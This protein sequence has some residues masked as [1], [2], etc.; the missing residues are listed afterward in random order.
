[1]KTVVYGKELNDE[2]LFKLRE[3][4]TITFKQIPFKNYCF[5]LKDDYENFNDPFIKKMETELIKSADGKEYIKLYYDGNFARKDTIEKLKEYGI[6][7]FEG[8]VD[9]IK[10][11]LIINQEVELH[12][13]G[14]KNVFIDIETVDTKPLTYDEKD[15][16]IANTPITAIA[17]KDL[18]G[19]INYLA[20][21]GYKKLNRNSSKIEV[22]QI[23]FEHEEALL[24]AYIDIIKEYD[25][26]YAWNGYRFD[27]PWLRQR[28]EIHKLSYP[29]I[30]EIDYLEMYKKD[31]YLNLQSFNLNNV[32]VH[33][34][35]GMIK[36]AITD[37]SFKFKDLKEVT[38]LDWKDITKLKKYYELAICEP[39]IMKEYNVQDVNLMLMIEEKNMFIKIHEMQAKIAHCLIKETMHNSNVSDYVIFKECI[40]RNIIRKS[41]PTKEEIEKIKELPGGA[42]TFCYK[43]GFY[44]NIANFDFKSHYPTSM[45]NFN[46]SIETYAGKIEPELE[47][48]FNKD[49]ISLINYACKLRIG[50]MTKGFVEALIKKKQI[51]LNVQSMEDLMF[52]F[53]KDY[54]IPEKLK[55]TDCIITPADI[56]YD[57]IGWN[58]HP[59]RYFK[60]I[61]AIIPKIC[62]EWLDKRDELKDK[63]K[64][65]MK[66]KK[67]ELKTVKPEKEI[68]ALVNEMPEYINLKLS[69]N[70]IKINL[71]SFYGYFG[72][73]GSRDYFYELPDTITTIGRYILKTMIHLSSINKYNIVAG[74]TDSVYIADVPQDKIVD[75][76]IIYYDF[77]KTFFK[78]FNVELVKVQKNPKTKELEN[79]THWTVFQLD[80]IVKAAIFIK[81]KR[82]YYLDEDE[83]K[84]Q[85]G[86]FKKTNTI[87]VAAKV[88]K[89]IVKKIL[90]DEFNLDF[91]NKYLNQ[92]SEDTFNNKLLI[93]D[94]TKYANVT[95]KIE[96][97]GK[98]VVDKKTG[99][100][101]I[102]KNGKI[103]YAPIPVH[104]EVAK[105]MIT[106]G[107]NVDV[108]EKIPYI[109]INNKPKLSGVHKEEFE[110]KNLTYCAA[111]YWT[112]IVS[113]VLEILLVT[114]KDLAMNEL[115]KYWN[116]TDK[117]VM[118]RAKQ[119]KTL[120]SL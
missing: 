114:H 90:F 97:Y 86:A 7:V 113:V 108:G 55:K 14:L 21:Q 102:K 50:S 4:D 43:P 58:V 71:N 40:K 85:G 73:R 56:N 51:E 111:Y 92:L 78:Q 80:K 57:V 15:K 28:C 65:I 13:E 112:N 62:A 67:T 59:H 103:Q 11:F 95:N 109:I 99:R 91:I 5:I 49:E 42:Y 66:D 22:E 2:I 72:F 117:Q 84:T 61:D 100:P 38:K 53:I 26:A 37:S 105:K 30:I 39:E 33:E 83:V 77:L 47:Q 35:K 20:N 104:I 16:I 106:D 115:K 87:K 88:Q 74:D 116:L 45:V 94:I 54:K 75:L 101:K 110:N 10:R 44:K 98:A 68:E 41:K 25:V 64:K 76:E 17:L 3:N 46:I 63:M 70:A 12:Q 31:T 27:F 89:E 18:T 120:F 79:N 107:L 60:K 6:K 48:I 118:T 1:M 23:F 81:K 34:F 32:A 69:Q 93:D 19:K 82:Y 29:D 8:D 9:S 96:N 119:Q 36:K 52:R 24:K